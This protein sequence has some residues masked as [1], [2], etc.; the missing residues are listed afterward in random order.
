MIIS[1]GPHFIDDLLTFTVTTHRFDTGVLTDADSVPTYRVYE[2]ETGTAILTGS[3][4]KL[5]DAGTT[6][7]YSEQITLSAA[8]GFEAGKSYSVY[9]AATVNSVAGGVSAS[10]KVSGNLPAAVNSIAANAI[11]ATS[12]AAN[13]ITSAKIATDAI[14]A[15]Q[16]AA[17][18]IGASELASDAVTEIQSGLATAA[19]LT[20]VDDLLDTEIAAIKTVVDGIATLLADT[21]TDVAAIRAV[22]D[23]LIA[24]QAEVTTLPAS[25]ATPL[26]KLAY[27]FQAVYHRLDVT[28]AKKTFYNGA[29]A[30]TYEQDLSDNGT[31]A[32]QSKVNAL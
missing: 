24:A 29:G 20:V 11:T 17:N 3:M 5:D 18:A 4:A 22:T 23:L 1:Q 19:A 2:D 14:G 12:I 31:T 27:L 6:G 32:S 28:N 13:A 8:N 10:F 7:F 30:A 26:A 25:N 21:D 15:A 16:I 9:V